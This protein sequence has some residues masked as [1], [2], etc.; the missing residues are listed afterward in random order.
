MFEALDADL[1]GAGFDCLRLG[2]IN[3]DEGRIVDACLHEI[4]GELDAGARRG[5]IGVDGVVH[6]AE[7]AARL[8]VAIGLAH[9]GVVDQQEAGFI[10]LQSGAVEFAAVEPFGKHGKALRA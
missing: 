5:D 3:R 2:V 1:P 8:Q 6:H 4:F 10:G 9:A 7:S